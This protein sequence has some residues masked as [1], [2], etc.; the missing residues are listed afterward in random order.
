[1]ART[2]CSHQWLISAVVNIV[3]DACNHEVIGKYIHKVQ[4]DELMQTL[5]FAAMDELERNSL[6]TCWGA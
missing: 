2:Q 3:R 1:M 5:D 6:L 4:F